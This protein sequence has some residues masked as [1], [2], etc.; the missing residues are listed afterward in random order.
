MNPYLEFDDRTSARLRLGIE[1]LLNI[2][3]VAETAQDRARSAYA[4]CMANQ[5]DPLA[6]YA[7]LTISEDLMGGIRGFDVEISQTDVSDAYSMTLEVSILAL[8]ICGFVKT[9]GR[10]MWTT[11]PGGSP[12]RWTPADVDMHE[13]FI[14]FFLD[15]D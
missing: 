2:P 4:V 14:D 5:R 12:P 1:D 11:E 13:L 9:Q 3:E 7:A 10:G 8:K 15:D 6:T